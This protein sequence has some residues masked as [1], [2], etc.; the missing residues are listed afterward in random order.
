MA[1]KLAL[2]IG[3]SKYE[4]GLSPIPTAV[5]DV[6]AMER[7]LQNPHL[8]CFE[9]KTL[10]NPDL[11]TMQIAIEELFKN[12][13]KDDLTLLFFSGHG[14]T[15][16]SNHLYLAT[17]STRKDAFYG[18]AV[19][20]SIV[21]NIMKKSPSRQQLVIL[22]CCYSGA[23]A[24][25]WQPKSTSVGC[26]LL[27]SSTSARQAFAA[28][29][30]GIYTNYI[31]EGIETGAA[32]LD[33]NGFISV[34]ELH[35]YAKKKVQLKKPQMKP[36]M[37][38]FKEGY[39]IQIARVTTSS[40][41][42]TWRCEYT[43]TEHLDAVNCVAISPD[44]QTL[45]SASA[46]CT[47][48]IWDL[49]TGRQIRSL[50]EHLDSVN[51]IAISP[52]GQTLVSGSS[53]KTIQIWNLHT[54]KQIRKLGGWL[55][56]HLDSINSLAIAPN[57]QT[58][59]SGS[60][61]HIIKLWN[62]ATGRQMGKLSQNLWGVYSIV[63]TPDGQA[64]VSDCLDH[65]IK[66]CHLDTQEILQIFTDH[67]D[68][69]WGIA[70]SP[71]S[72]ILASASQDCTVKIWDLETGKLLHTLR[73]HKSPVHSISFSS[74]G[75]IIASGSYDNTIRIWSVEN[76]QLLQTLTGH[77]NGVNSVAFSPDGRVIASASDDKTIKIWRG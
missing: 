38:P 48:K 17:R 50:E 15:D 33:K 8:G 71:N 77:E 67:L 10:E 18:T 29:E 16:D 37:H 41:V 68:W 58:L 47:V 54:G 57:G 26:A 25:N 52:D 22:D 53:D 28:E 62:L 49:N 73:D 56:V 65:T 69:I 14:I 64:I 66:L 43:L 60:R 3:V 35:D 13:E 12:C 24:V 51:C 21:Q 76:W 27:A 75:Q 31:V 32:D 30:S 70:I 46:D 1:K 2:L 11:M 42:R 34:D 23:F 59:I 61:D 20:A 40:Q 72:K 6:K 45:V 55:P 7:V 36:E 39:K 63:V 9:V 44:S 5:S 74:D 19:S 4:A